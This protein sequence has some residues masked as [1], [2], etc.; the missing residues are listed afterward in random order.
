MLTACEMSQHVRR[1]NMGIV[2]TLRRTSMR[3]KAV[4][5][6]AL[7]VAIVPAAVLAWGP[8][9][10]TFTEAVPATYV[11]FNS[12]TDNSVY[13][14]ERNFV[15][16]KDAA[17]T[18]NGGWSDNLTVE[19]GKEYVVRMYVHNN[20]A[21]NLN[22][23]AEN[24]RA[25]A[26]V[27][28]TTGKSVSISGFINSS[29]ANPTQVWDDVTLNANQDFNLAYVSGSASYHNN[30]IGKAPQGIALPDSIVTNAGALLGY[31]KLDG[32]IPGCYQYSGYV[33]FKVKPQFATPTPDFS[34]D[35]KVRL[36][37][38][39]GDWQES[40]AA[41]PG[42]TVNYRMEINN[43]GTADLKNVILKDQLP[44]GMSFVPG[45]VKILD[46]N[47]PSG[48]YVTDGDKIVTSG[49]NTGGYN[50]GT[51]AIVVF[52]AKVADNA[53]LPTCGPQTL[54]NTAS[55]QP[56]GQNPKS[57]TA[58]VTTTKDCE[59][60]KKIDV[61]DLTTKKIV[62]IDEKDFDSKKYSKDLNDCKEVPATIQVCNLADNK[63]ITINEKD[64]DSKKHSKNLA[65][66]E[67]K[68]VQV[69]DLTSKTIVTIDSKNFDSKKHSTNLAD[70]KMCPL[71]GMNNIPANSPD[72]V[73]NPVTTLPETGIDGGFGTFAGIGLLTAVL[74]YALSSSRIRSLLIG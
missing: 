50:P 1:D 32:K 13:G 44:Q 47:N 62:T 40:I 37:G 46:T 58:D 7:A 48:A 71:P 45:T 23:V 21:Q 53:N 54:T 60:V 18:A 59:E 29:N 26:S 24:V 31:D 10:T 17:N 64:F 42:D 56:E 38:P 61:C 73:N 4:I 9:R 20:A 15:T 39:K 36:D 35:K 3:T 57:D 55:A 19:P 16:I 11:T 66:C 72:C 6:T 74:G 68:T 52:N 41:K 65:D 34:I 33:Y 70:C 22:L 63:I 2:T 51:N 67:Q 27:P 12:I 43:T 8:S 5:A 49:I 69:C 25:S 28:T 14:D 30:S